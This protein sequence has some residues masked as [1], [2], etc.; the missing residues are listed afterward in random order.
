M[1][2]TIEVS[3]S[4][5]RAEYAWRRCGH[6]ESLCATG[7]GE[8]QSIRAGSEEEFITEHYWGYTACRSGCNE[9]QVEHP[10]WTVWREVDAKL[11][12]DVS[13]LY[14]ERFVESLS[15]CPASALIADGSPIAVRCKSVLPNVG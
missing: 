12:A 9:Y 4:Q 6:W 3:P 1:R 11:N 14:G 7:R 8:A 5:I 2:H 10:R 13:S 15:A